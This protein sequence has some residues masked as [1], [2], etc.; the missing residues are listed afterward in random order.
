M[1][2]VFYSLMAIC[3]TFIPSA[4]AIEVSEDI[5][6]QV[7]KD[8]ISGWVNDPVIVEAVKA[9]N[10]AHADLTDEEITELDNRWREGDETLID[11]YFDT[12]ISKFL[13]DKSENSDGLFT[14]VFVMDNK[15]LIVGLDN[16]TS[17]YMQGDEAKWQETYKV[18]PDAMHMSEV[19]FDESTQTFQFQLSAPVT[20]NGKNIGAIT[21][22]LN[23]EVLDM[24]YQ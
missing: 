17:D 22:G 18:G 2:L 19:E 21:V 6:K 3:F 10:S 8:H 9:Q 12:D 16:R 5:K 20:E 23:A 15:G 14:E 1:K 11:P 13:G 4:Q 24:M 7:F